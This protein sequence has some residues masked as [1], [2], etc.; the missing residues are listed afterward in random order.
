MHKL[1]NER[2]VFIGVVLPRPLD[3]MLTYTLTIHSEDQDL[4]GMWVL[5]PLG[6]ERV[7]GCIWAVESTSVIPKKKLRPI[8]AIL[9]WI[10]PLSTSLIRLLTTLA[11]YY[12]V[13]LGEALNL[14]MPRWISQPAY[15]FNTQRDVTPS[16][17]RSLAL[18]DPISPTHEPQ[19]FVFKA[20]ETI[21]DLCPLIHADLPFY[22]KQAEMK[23]WVSE[24]HIIR[25]KVPRGSDRISFQWQRSSTVTAQTK[26][27]GRYAQIIFELLLTHTKLAHK[28][29]LGHFPD[30][31]KLAIKKALRSLLER[32][33]VVLTSKVSPV[34]PQSKSESRNEQKEKLTLT[35]E[36]D[37]AVEILKAQDDFQVTLLHGV[38][39]SG[40]TEVYLEV[41][42]SV[43]S[44]GQQALVLV[45]EIGLT[46]QTVDRFVHR[47]DTPIYSWHSQMSK[48]DRIET[49]QAISRQGPC[50]LIGARSA[51]F[52]PLRALGVIIVDEAHDSSY[53]QG[54][55]VRYHARDMAILRG[56]IE[57]CRVIL[58]T[59][60]PSL[61]SM[62]NAFCG[63][64]QLLELKK[65]PEGALMPLV[66]IIDL[67]KS[68]SVTAEATSITQSLANAIDQRLQ[69][70]EQTILFLNRRGFSQSIRCVGCGYLF[71]CPH[72]QLA[73]PWHLTSKQLQCH[74][75]DFKGTPPNQCPQ[76][77]ASS[78]APIGRGTERIESQ[79]RALFPYAKIIRL[80]Q[81]S[82]LS[83]QELHSLMNSEQVDILIGTQMVTKGHDFPRVTLV[84]VI[85]ADVGVDLPDFRANERSYQL[86]SQVAGRAGRAHLAGEVIVQTYRPNEE[87]LLAAVTHDYQRFFL[88]EMTL[89]EVIGYPP[90]S[91]LATIR[92]QGQPTQK[93]HEALDGLKEALAS[94]PLRFRGPTLAPLNMTRGEQRWIVLMMAS[95]RKKLH[96][97][98]E[99]LTHIIKSIRKN[100]ISCFV[101]TD[102]LDFF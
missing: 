16:A 80:D 74:H 66:R 79:L 93:L 70:N 55:G 60:T 45:P 67:T 85:D 34:A 49:W 18:I 22:I 44:K 77:A 69:K 20:L 72:C 99:A 19:P 21:N 91:Y 42:E 95:Q 89:R 76:C 40:K 9:Q 14:A 33:Q 50:V 84:G 47:L 101:D 7:I 62:H 24:R 53:K 43:L 6:R 82:T 73:L 32:D 25:L 61:E 37:H 87:R 41:I 100:G 46:P 36:Q 27:S 35:A 39:G 4:L 102:P 59:A 13:P 88:H 15:M 8:L 64:Y 63:K 68:R 96:S 28:E 92:I 78:L 57:N 23:S 48:K 98:L 81:D 31:K 51:L 12:F 58:G 17:Q 97:Q 86:L 54:D 65:R 26:V 38:T 90:F 71:L 5:V 75:C 11:T 3:G 2:E 83:A 94:C 56:S 52:S 1:A 30:H 10:P 29:L